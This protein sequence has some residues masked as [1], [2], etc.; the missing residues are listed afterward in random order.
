[1]IV[2]ATF[3]FR[4]VIGVEFSPELSEIATRNIECARGRLRCLN[5]EVVTVDATN[6]QVPAEA[7]VVFFYNPFHGPVLASVLHNIP[8]SLR[9][10]P[11]K[12][13]VVFKNTPH[14]EQYLGEG[15]WLSKRQ[16]FRA[17]DA[18]HRILI[19]EASQHG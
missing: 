16:E 4:K 18:E 7:T 17:C 11:R 9:K 12:M 2:A 6:Y 15:S 3:P 1:M 13:T 5:T 14:L 10:S 8:E 19:L